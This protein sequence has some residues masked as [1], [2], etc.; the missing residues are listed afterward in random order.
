MCYW[1]GRPTEDWMFSTAYAEDANWNDAFWKHDRFNKLLKAA[2]AEL[3]EKK[4]RDMYVDMQRIVRDEG[5]TP[6]PVFASILSAASKKLAHG[7]VAGNW[8]FDGM[9]LTERWWFA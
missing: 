1:G 5:G 2:R 8:E 6:C 9:R 3:D 4:R 7:P